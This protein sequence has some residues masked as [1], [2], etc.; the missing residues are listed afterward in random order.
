MVIG[1]MVEVEDGLKPVDTVV[2]NP[3]KGLNDNS[4]ITIIQQ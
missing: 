3:P 4:K 2:I 1:D